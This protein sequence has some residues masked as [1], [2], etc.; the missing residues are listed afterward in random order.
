[1]LNL[2]IPQLV[3]WKVY[4]CCYSY[5]ILV[6]FEVFQ[7]RKEFGFVKVFFNLVALKLQMLDSYD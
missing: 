2:K 5:M 4:L 7:W 1:M 6:D 3:I